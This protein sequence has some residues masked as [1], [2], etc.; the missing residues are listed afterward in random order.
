MFCYYSLPGNKFV[1][2][3]VSLPGIGVV[4]LADVVS[5]LSPA[6]DDRNR[7]IGQWL[8]VKPGAQQGQWII[9]PINATY[10]K[11]LRIAPTGGNSGMSVQATVSDPPP[12]VVPGPE[13][14]TWNYTQM[15]IPNLWADLAAGGRDEDAGNGLWGLDH[16]FPY[17]VI[18]GPHLAGPT[19]NWKLFVDSPA[20]GT[21]DTD[22]N[23]YIR[24]HYEA[25][26]RLYMMYLPPGTN[27]RF[28]PLRRIDWHVLGEAEKAGGQWVLTAQSNAIDGSTDFPVH[29]TWAY[30][31]NP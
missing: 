6:F 31:H 10:M 11:L 12:P 17:P 25:Q 18:G 28:V 9:D 1:S 20:I 27:S 19:P 13:V 24:L 3:F 26:F 16:S 21:S 29:P 14:G 5:P 2:A 30:V 15:L 22:G 8:F 4:Y 7:N 23:P